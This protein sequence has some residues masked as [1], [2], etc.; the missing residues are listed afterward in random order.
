MTP[1]QLIMLNSYQDAPLKLPTGK[2]NGFY[3][4]T[5]YETAWDGVFNGQPLPMVLIFIPYVVI[6]KNH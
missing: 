6:I 2:E 4:S 1:G 3:N 5:G